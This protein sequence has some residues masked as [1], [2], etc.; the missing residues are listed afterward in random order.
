MSLNSSMHQLQQLEAA[1]SVHINLGCIQEADDW[2]QSK[3]DTSSP[4]CK[5]CSCFPGG[6]AYTLEGDSAGQFMQRC[7][8]AL[9]AWAA[10]SQYP[11][12]LVSPLPCPAGGHHAT[13]LPGELP[14]T[15]ACS[16]LCPCTP[17][18]DACVGV[19]QL[20][21]FDSVPTGLS[22]APACKPTACWGLPC[23]SRCFRGPRMMSARLGLAVSLTSSTSVL[24][25]PTTSAAR[26]VERVQ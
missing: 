12:Q 2:P 15:G 5:A 13:S 14:A 10:P 21:A 8:S 26:W 22:V 18:G 23:A 17:N 24:L 3:V 11:V 25:W 1:H 20:L 6:S 9:L 16:C 19:P 7:G 4:A